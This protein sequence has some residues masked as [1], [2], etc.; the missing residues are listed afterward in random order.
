MAAVTIYLDAQ[1]EKLVAANAEASGLTKSRWIAQALQNQVNEVWPDQSLNF[2]GS[3]PDFP[4]RDEVFRTPGNPA[5][6]NQKD[7]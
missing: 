7:S 2:A 3:F 4:L 1:T 5:N 6:A